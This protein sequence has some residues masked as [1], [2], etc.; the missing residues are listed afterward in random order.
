M[1]VGHEQKEIIRSHVDLE[2]D[3]CK[4]H[5]KACK[6]PSPPPP[7]ATGHMSKDEPHSTKD[8]GDIYIHV[9]IRESIC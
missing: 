1:V 6:V 3:N 9:M 8:Y 7:I 4:H 2:K 5:K